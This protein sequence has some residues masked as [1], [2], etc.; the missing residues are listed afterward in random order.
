MRVG[1]FLHQILTK[2]QYYQKGVNQ[3]LRPRAYFENVKATIQKLPV[4]CFNRLAQTLCYLF[5]YST[6]FYLVNTNATVE[7]A[8]SVIVFHFIAIQNINLQYRLYCI[9]RLNGQVGRTGSGQKV[10]KLSIQTHSTVV[11]FYKT[12]ILCLTNI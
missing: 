4:F 9:V 1:D 5:I 3:N 8:Y 7:Y 2:L 6:L 10:L 12:L 11:F